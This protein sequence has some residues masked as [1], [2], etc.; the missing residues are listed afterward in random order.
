[1]SRT[2]FE[3]LHQALAH[4]APVSLGPVPGDVLRAS[5][6]V[7]FFERDSE[8]CLIFVKRP[9]GDYKHAGQIAFPGGK[10]DGAE[11]ALECALRETFEE[12]GIA[13]ED[14]RV[15]GE[16]DE[17]DT[18]VTGFR[19]TP[20]VGVV[21]YPY[22][23]RPQPREVERILQ[24]PLASLLDPSIFRMEQREAFGHTYR[25]YY[26]GVPEGLIWG[27]TAGILTPLL[28]LIRGLPSGREYTSRPR[29]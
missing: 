14:V 10:R 11:T 17:Y 12:V 27:V 19:V 4:R 21:P 5:V 23:L 6:L 8:V 7:P 9:E 24:V 22:P 25:I 2:L 3:E 28:E 20:I 15:L 18:R 26:Y 1:M 29:S 16:L 13:P